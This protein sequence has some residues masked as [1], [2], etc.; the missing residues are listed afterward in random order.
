MPSDSAKLARLIYETFRECV[1]DPIILP[2]ED[3]RPDVRILWNSAVKATA[4]AAVD[5][6]DDMSN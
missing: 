3:A 4:M 1:G 6:Q 2:W 5:R